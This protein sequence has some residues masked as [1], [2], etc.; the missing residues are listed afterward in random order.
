MQGGRE[1]Q[2]DGR[3]WVGGRDGGREDKGGRKR[4]S[5]R[6]REGGMVGRREG[7]KELR[8]KDE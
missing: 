3:R 7:G 4:V 1:G 5:E 8:A 6:A 2:T